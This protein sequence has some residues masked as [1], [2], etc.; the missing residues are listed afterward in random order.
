M[1]WIR[2]TRRVSRTT[3]PAGCRSA[4]SSMSFAGCEGPIVGADIVE[5]NP[6]RDLNGVTAMVA[7]K[8]VKEIGARMAT[9][10]VKARRP[11]QRAAAADILRGGR[12]LLPVTGGSHESCTWRHC[13][14]GSSCCAVCANTCARG[15]H[16][17][18][19]QAGLP[20]ESL[21]R[22]RRHAVRRQRRRRWRHCTW[23]PARYKAEP[24]IAP[25]AFGS[26][27]ILGVFV[28]EQRG[29]LWVCSDD[30]T[31]SKIASP[32]TGPTA[33][34]GFDAARAAR[35]R[36]ASRCPGNDPFC[37]DIAL[38]ADGT[39]YVSESTN[40]R[41][42]KLSPDMKGFTVWA[43]DKQLLDIDGIAFGADGNL[44]ANTYAGNGFFR[45]D[46]AG[47]RRRGHR[48]ARHAAAAVS[49]GWHAHRT[50]NTFLM[51]EGSGSSIASASRATRCSCRP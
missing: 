47:R 17:T 40:G 50:G 26:R 9:R 4:T 3:S 14:P 22:R 2:P 25:A 5:L 11:F 38:A 19:R 35:A 45:I 31:S 37:N 42:L 24:W 1:R 34:K 41:V 10:S 28:D 21:G 18:A 48:E 15:D 20:R 6:R 36:S 30:L 39:V 43:A 12:T 23:R 33:L 27:S 32:G 46:G 29:L 8:L 16:R 7:A 44:Y 49:P 51:V 13:R